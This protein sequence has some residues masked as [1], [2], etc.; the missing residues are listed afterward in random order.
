MKPKEYLS[1]ALHYKRRYQNAL[2]DL[3][4]I[5]S[6]ATGLTAIRY[7]KDQVQ[8]S[9]D[10]DQL[11]NYMIRLERAERRAL[12]ASEE[13]FTAYEQ[14]WDQVAQIGP[15]LY[16]DVL[17]LRYIK[18]KKLYEI[19]DEMAYSYE[20]MRKIHGRALREFGLRF[21]EVLQEGTKRN[22]GKE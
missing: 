3:E 18:G 16:S 14:I 7:D 6:M 19:A 22:N 5:R 17:Y 13:Y 10:S 15:Q 21:P 8:T 4:Y 9:P 12:K 1:R 20:F 2:E 11:A